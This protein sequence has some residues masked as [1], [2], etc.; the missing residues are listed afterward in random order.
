MS[1]ADSADDLSKALRDNFALLDRGRPLESLRE[2]IFSGA[3]INDFQCPLCGRTQVSSLDHFLPKEVF[4]EFSILADN[5]VPV[6]ERCN[7]LKGIECDRSNGLLMLHAY[8]DTFPND[9]LLHLDI[10][11]S[12]S[13][14]IAYSLHQSVSV[15][16]QLFER[17][18]KHYSVLNLLEFYQVE[19]IAEMTDQMELYDETYRSTGGAG[20]RRL[21]ASLSRGAE[22]RG[23]NHWKSVLYRDLGRSDEFCD[24]GYKLLLSRPFSRDLVAKAMPSSD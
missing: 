13:V 11:F 20:M 4:P 18:L 3:R 22:K 1:L 21:L 15:S 17:I 8:F 7:R 9:E 16:D 6:C 10:E 2:Y 14:E 23:V 5:L 24:G 12:L 19:A